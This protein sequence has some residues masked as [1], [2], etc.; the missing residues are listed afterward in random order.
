MITELLRATPHIKLTIITSVIDD[1]IVEVGDFIAPYDGL[2]DISL[3]EDGEI[4]HKT[5]NKISH[6][7]SY[8]HPP[9]GVARDYAAAI[10][11]D[12]LGI[13]QDRQKFLD[14]VYK[15]LLNGCEIIIMQK[16]GSIDI[17]STLEL[18]D[19]C[20]FRAVNYIAD[21]VDGYDVV[22]GKK[23]HMWGKGL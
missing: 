21:L 1:T 2:I 9:F 8:S 20:E 3:Y 7:K 18:L 10:V 22:V 11:I 6:I 4:S 17:E 13:H 12:V 5:I 14:S 16:Q 23:L 15:I 19:S